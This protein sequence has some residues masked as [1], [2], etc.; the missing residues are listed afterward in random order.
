MDAQQL[1][2]ADIALC[3][4]RVQ[5]DRC[6]ELDASAEVQLLGAGD[7]EL[8]AGE[9]DG[10]TDGEIAE[11]PAGDLEDYRATRDTIARCLDRFAA[12]RGLLRYQPY[13]C[14]ENVWHLLDGR[15]AARE[16]AFAVFVSNPTRSVAMWAQRAALVPGT[17]VVWDY[18][19]VAVVEHGEGYEVWDLDSSEGRRLPMERWL[20]VSFEATK[21]LPEQLWPQFRVVDAERYLQVLA[22]DRSHMRDSAGAL[23]RRAPPWPPI[24]ERAHSNIDQFIEME[25]EFEGDVFDLEAFRRRF[26]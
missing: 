14:E 11:P 24:G 2:W 22:S 19:V 9:T 10:D 3:M 18:H 5:A 21:V 15:L 6:R 12:E 20:E 17:P 25:S 16:R 8:I 1:A 23:I 13:W 7:P 26:G 4:E